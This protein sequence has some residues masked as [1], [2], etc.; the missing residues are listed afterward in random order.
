MPKATEKIT[1]SAA[2][3]I[4]CLATLR[5]FRGIE[6][7]AINKEIR[8]SIG[9]DLQN[10]APN[11]QLP[12]D[13]LVATTKSLLTAIGQMAFTEDIELLMTNIDSQL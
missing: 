12:A 6:V 5:Q 13:L 10:K 1:L 8:A 11:D 2:Q 4:T 9:G 7:F 3:W